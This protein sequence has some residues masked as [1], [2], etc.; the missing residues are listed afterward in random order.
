MKLVKFN[1]ILL[2]MYLFLVA[3]TQQAPQPTEEGA[4]NGE[5]AVSSEEPVQEDIDTIREI[6][7]LYTNDEHGWMEGQ[8]EDASAA[9]LMGLWQEVEGYTPDADGF[10]LLSGGDM[11]TGP[12]ISTWFE[13]KSMAEVM[14]EMGYMA[15]AVGNHEFDFGLDG[16]QARAE[17]SDFPFLSANIRYKSNGETPTDLGIEPYIIKTI[18]DVEVGII[19]LT[20]TDTPITTN[21]TNVTNFDFIHYE[22]ALRE[23]VPQLQ[24]EG[25]ELILV[26]THICRHE[27]DSL[28]QHVDDL[29]I[30]LFGG[31][32][33][34][35][36]FASKEGNSILLTGGSGLSSYAQATIL[37]D[38]ATDTVVDAN[39]DTIINSGGTPDPTIEAIISKWR[40]EANIELNRI[41][42]YSDS[43]ILQRSPDMQTLITESWLLSYPSADVAIT[44]LGGM[45][46]DLPAGDISLANIITVMPFDNVIIELTLT[47]Q[48]LINVLSNGPA[49]VG[50]IHRQGGQWVFNETNEPLELD[51]T[52]SVLVN[53]FMYSGGDDYGMLAEFDSEG[54]DTAI[55]WRQPIIDWIET[56]NSS[57]ERPLD[58]SLLLQNP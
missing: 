8:S 33:C 4:D 52:Y 27:L 10:I 39:Y 14:N 57:E 22:T 16:L 44:N 36:L 30:H 43:T 48:E 55:Q 46:A 11:W 20:T 25:A 49:A 21:P 56:Q 35:E 15:A 40:E 19:G 37:F 1:T 45:R 47:G 12:A 17:Q 29:D 41:I 50:G 54:Y 53:D 6:T 51:A 58:I 42:G 9:H 18:N 31:G 38:T 23:V 3:C 13:G 34:N 26:P 32:H 2:L 28:A 7:I 5:T 24:A